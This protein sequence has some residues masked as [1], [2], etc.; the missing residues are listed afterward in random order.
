MIKAA[1]AER[2]VMKTMMSGVASGHAASDVVGGGGV[3]A[4]GI[5]ISIL[6]S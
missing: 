6:I 1:D 4:V 3:I 5:V 2:L